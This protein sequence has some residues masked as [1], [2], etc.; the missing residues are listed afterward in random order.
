MSLNVLEFEH[1]FKS[2]ILN[3]SL[4]VVYLHAAVIL[5][6][7]MSAAMEMFLKSESC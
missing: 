6:S 5:N 7:R 1:N 3:F 4:Q 2:R